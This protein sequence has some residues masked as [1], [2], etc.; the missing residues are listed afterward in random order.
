MKKLTKFF[1]TFIFYRLM[2]YE[3]KFL[4]KYIKKKLQSLKKI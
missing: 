2:F 3:L 4:F 1:F